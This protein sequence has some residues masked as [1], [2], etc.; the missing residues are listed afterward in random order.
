MN[1][2]TIKSN[3]LIFASLLLIEIQ[4]FLDQSFVICVLDYAY[5]KYPKRKF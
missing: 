1:P 4:F 5:K 3:G 2:Y